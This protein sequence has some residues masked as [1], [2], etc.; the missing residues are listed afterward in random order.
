MLNPI[1]FR[2]IACAPIPLATARGSVTSFCPLRGREPVFIF[3]AKPASMVPVTHVSGLYTPKGEG[4]THKFL[5][6]LRT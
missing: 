1:A 2:R 5:A 6:H 4:F 3:C